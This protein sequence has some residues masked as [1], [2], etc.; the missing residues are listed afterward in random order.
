VPIRLSI[1]LFH[2]PNYSADFDENSYFASVLKMSCD[3]RM[4]FAVL[5]GTVPRFNRNKEVC[6]ICGV[7]RYGTVGLYLQ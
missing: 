3:W 6:V 7:T 5:L 2:F 4:S 1:T